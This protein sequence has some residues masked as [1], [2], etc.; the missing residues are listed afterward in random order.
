M[1]SLNPRKSFKWVSMEIIPATSSKNSTK[2]TNF[3]NN[4]LIVDAH[5]KLPKIYG[6]EKITTEEVMYK[7]D[8]FQTRF[9]KVDEFG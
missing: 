1:I 6:M 3:S 9:V 7:L 8:M 4:L 5:Y 2:D